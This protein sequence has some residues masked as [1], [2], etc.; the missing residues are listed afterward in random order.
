MELTRQSF[1]GGKNCKNGRTLTPSYAICRQYLETPA[2]R[3]RL[4]TSS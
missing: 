1:R 3:H 2:H 4:T